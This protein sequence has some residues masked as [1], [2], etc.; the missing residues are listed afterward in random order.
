MPARLGVEVL[1][2]AAGVKAAM[3]EAL[4]AT[5]NYARGA[6]AAFAGVSDAALRLQLAQVKLGVASAKFGEGSVGQAQALQRYRRELDA[7]QASS[8][9][10][11]SSLGR[12]LTTYVALP[13]A[14]IGYEAVKMGVT[15]NRQMLLIRTQAGDTTDSIK[16]LSDAVLKM[17]PETGTSPDQLAQGLFH[18]ASIGIRGAQAL[19]VLKT[20]AIAA[21]MGMG[22]L[23]DVTTA[24]G[25]AVV[26]G[27]RG[28][29]NYKQA[30]ASLIAIAG[31]GNMHLQDL[32]DAI[33]TGLL[34]KAHNAGV[35]L[36][37]VGAAL[38]VLTD[39]GMPARR[40]ATQLGTTFALMMDPS[41]AAIK[42]LNDMGIGQNQLATDLQKPN[43]L[44]TVLQTLASGMERVGNVQGKQDILSAF[45]RSRQSGAILTLVESLTAAYSRYDTKLNQITADQKA[46]SDNIAQY[47]HSAYFKLHQDLATLEA[48]LVKVGNSMT[49][50][51]E[52]LARGATEIGNAFGKLPGPVKTDLGAIVALLAVGGP[53]LLAGTGVI[54]MIAAIRTAFGLMPVAAAPAVAETVAEVDTIGAAS[55]TATAEVGGLRDALIG[56]GSIEVL[57]PLAALA[58]GIQ[59]LVG[60]SKATH[61]LGRST[62]QGGM[63]GEVQEEHGKYYIVS[64]QN[65]ARGGPGGRRQISPE[66]AARLLGHPVAGSKL[67]AIPHG[68][69]FG[70]GPDGPH[71]TTSHDPSKAAPMSTFAIPYAL[72]LEQAKA[73]A[74]GS[75]KQVEQA[76]ADIRTWIDK[77]LAAHRFTGAAEVAAYNELA[78]LDTKSASAATKS[79]DAAKK[80]AAAEKKAAEERMQL[81][82]EKILGIGRFANAGEISLAADER[83]IL[84]KAL[85]DA[86]VS[87]EHLQTRR[88]PKAAKNYGYGRIFRNTGSGSNASLAEV[89]KATA[90]MTLDQLL[91]EVE[92]VFGKDMPAGVERELEKINKVLKFK[93]ISPD[94]KAAIRARL[95]EIARELEGGLHKAADISTKNYHKL[96]STAFADQLGLTGAQRAKA[97]ALYAQQ[98]AHSG[99]VPNGPA[100][101]GV[102]ITGNVHVHGV[103]DPKKFL[104]ELQRI[105]KSS[106]TSI[107]GQHGGTR[108]A[109]G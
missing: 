47:Q 64:P 88:T 40:A 84:D 2:D 100:G 81:E 107:R 68:A 9:A 62:G 108:L 36:N 53:L 90:H 63:A 35:S 60:A 42:A 19:G 3:G 8:L 12:S 66:E 31:S 78:T 27:I 71:G 83:K 61:N 75:A 49:P 28:V 32:A 87:S 33:G 79:V 52:T 104:A 23:N 97:E 56:L 4:A 15:F 59:G 41:K 92:T 16:Q 80:K 77:M 95:E 21:S 14:V 55:V 86:G 72:Q 37:E 54:K 89:T 30:M 18:L 69:G 6:E 73:A 57:G 45:G 70:E 94:V 102:L 109:L 50:M 93:F 20:S 13:A 10:A 91:K 24:L 101:N 82:E 7:T 25:G 17:A 74:S 58:L 22:N 26:T 103:Q 46:N 99:M 44:L 65:A 39:R 96:S 67:T 29:E 38:A 34:V 11:A 1:G 106:G 98:Q 5:E 105:A 76:D 51:V 43:G 48:D 85:A